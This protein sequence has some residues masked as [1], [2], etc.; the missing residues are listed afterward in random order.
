MKKR[1]IHNV[2]IN[3]KRNS[4]HLIRFEKLTRRENVHL[5]PESI[6]EK[7]LL[8]KAVQLILLL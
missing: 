3:L 5:V 4:I 2:A 8:N 7:Q 1:I 6:G